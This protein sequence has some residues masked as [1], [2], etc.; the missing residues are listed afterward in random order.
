M[1][2]V[3]LTR[4]GF[5][6]RE[7]YLNLCNTLRSLLEMSIIPIFNENDTV[8]VEEIKFGDNDT[9]SALIA[10][11]A[12]ADLLIILSDIDGL[13]DKD[14]RTNSDAKL[15]HQVQEISESIRKNSGTKGSNMSSG[16]MFTK[17]AAAD[18]VLP[19][20]IPLVIANGAREEVIYQILEGQEVGTLFVP[21]LERR[22]A[23]KQWIASGAR[24]EGRIVIDA[25][26]VQALVER[27]SSLLPK[28]ITAVEGS[29]ERG[30]LVAVVDPQGREIARGLCNYD[31]RDLQ[32]IQ[33][34][35]SSEIE[36]ILGAKDFDEAIHRDNLV[37]S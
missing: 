2:Q 18:V 5:N 28:G 1:A 34:H 23:R 24:P 27:G 32:K 37:I 36:E 9:L 11:A 4:V 6:D 25:G 10:C 22:H 15:I 30:K 29:F 33:G 17:L 3:L 13:Y 20:G 7:R 12:N 35:R 16:G 26:A 8:A 21:P 31:S 19:A 14:P